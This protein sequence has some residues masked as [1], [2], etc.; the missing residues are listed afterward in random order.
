MNNNQTPNFGQDGPSFQKDNVR[1]IK[2]QASLPTGLIVGIVLIAL[3]FF[4]AF[5]CTYVVKEDEVAVVKIFG[6][7]QKNHR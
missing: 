7:T 1:P 4:V 6:E 3:A 2:P 5:S